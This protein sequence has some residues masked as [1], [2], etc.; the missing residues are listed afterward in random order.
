MGLGVVTRADARIVIRRGVGRVPIRQPRRLDLE[1]RRLCYPCGVALACPDQNAPV[2]GPVVRQFWKMVGQLASRQR[3]EWDL[4][5][6]A[7]EDR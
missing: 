2:R 3:P 4:R 6:Y 5:F 7:S 1:C